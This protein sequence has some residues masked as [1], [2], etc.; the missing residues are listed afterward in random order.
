MPDERPQHRML[1]WTLCIATLDRIEILSTCVALALRQTRPPAQIVIVDASSDWQ[2]NRDR[3]SRL[4]AE[5]N[6]RPE[7]PDLVYVQA[8]ARSSA[9]QRNQG[10]ALS[11]ADVLFLIDDDSMMYPDCAAEAMTVYEADPDRRIACVRL[12]PATQPPGEGTVG[13]ARKDDQGAAGGRLEGNRLFWLFRRH[14]LMMATD[15]NF[16]PYDGPQDPAWRDRA[17]LPVDLGPDRMDTAWLIPGYLL[18]VRRAVAAAEGFDPDLLAYCPGEDLD[19]TYRFARHGANV[20]AL[21]ARVYH[22]E[23]AAGRLKRH[24]ALKLALMNQAFLLRKHSAHLPAHAALYAWRL[25]RRVL[26]EALKDG[27]T[28]RWTFP[29]LRGA[30]SAAAAAPAI[31]THDRADLARW[32]QNRQRRVLG[33]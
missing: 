8:E 18:T 5:T 32:Y 7:A 15:L 30:L 22:H 21:R 2:A 4:V 10:I 17:N 27:L 9:R 16:I 31:F 24:R 6:D 12:S 1:S 26:A 11:H 23:A 28:R 3:I 33:A 14:V 13:I 20:T 29:Q 19:A 25:L